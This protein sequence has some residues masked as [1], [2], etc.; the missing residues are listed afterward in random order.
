MAGGAAGAEPGAAGAVKRGRSVRRLGRVLALLAQAERIIPPLLF[1]GPPAAGAD[2]GCTVPLSVD[3][4][5][6]V[7]G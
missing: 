2:P 5:G 4:G 6:S 3:G 7:T 1:T